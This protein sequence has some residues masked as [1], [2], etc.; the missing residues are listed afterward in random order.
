MNSVDC[1]S[2]S[3][4]AVVD[5]SGHVHVATSEAKIKEAP[6]WKSTDIEGSTALHGIAC[7]SSTSCVAVDGE[8]HVLDLTINSSGEATVSKEDL[9]GTNDLTGIACAGPLALF[10]LIQGQFRDW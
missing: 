6:G 10:W 7:T 2:S 4:C 9:D 8:G 5:S 1:L 3:F